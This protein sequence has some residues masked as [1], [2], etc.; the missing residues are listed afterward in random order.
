MNFLRHI[1]ASSLVLLAAAASAYEAP[2]FPFA[3]AVGYP[4]T[5]AISYE[6]SSIKGWAVDLASISFGEEVADEWKSPEN[7]LGPATGVMESVLVLGRGG[8]VVLSF[9]GA[10]GDGPGDDFAIFENSISDTFLELAYVEVSTDGL[11]FVRFPNYSL[12]QA[13]V[14]GFGNLS[15]TFVHGY[16]GKYRNGFGTPF[17]LKTLE[18][19]Y[20]AALVGEAGFSPEYR[21]QLIDGFEHL[22]L[23]DIRFVKI[24][25]IPGDGR[26]SDAEG[27]AIYDPFPTVITAGFD[28]DAVAVLNWGKDTLVSFE[29]WSAGY[30]LAAQ[31]TTDS[32]VDGWSQFMEYL[33]GTNPE[34]PASLPN[35]RQELVKREGNPFLRMEYV[36]N[37]SADT[38]L[39]IYLSVDG[40]SWEKWSA[41]PEVI[42]ESRNAQSHEITERLEIP[43]NADEGPLLVRFGAVY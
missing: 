37:G 29:E 39:E 13:P 30:G 42:L 35:V 26:E 24:I 14:G 6:D 43:Y 2:V 16:A 21:S 19:A 12:T 23:E 4:G 5:T 33:F 31:A 38:P 41:D 17:D 34:D 36:R 27:F 25:D 40:Q 9:G 28:L 1:Y 11:H 32:D 7:A 20:L 3:P 8:Q 22:D 10:I 15:P 18:E